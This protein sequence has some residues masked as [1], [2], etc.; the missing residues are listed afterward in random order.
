VRRLSI[1]KFI[2]YPYYAQVRA[3]KQFEA[4]PTVDTANI[5]Y[6]LAYTLDGTPV[7]YTMMPFLDRNTNTNHTLDIDTA[8][9]GTGRTLVSSIAFFSAS[10][11]GAFFKITSGAATGLVE[12]TA[13]T[14]DVSVTVRV[15]K[16]IGDATATANWEESAWSDYRGWPRS[17]CFYQQR[18]IYGGN[19][20]FPNTIWGSRIGNFQWLD[21]AGYSD[22]G[23]RT[24][25][26]QDANGIGQAVAV[27]YGTRTNIDPLR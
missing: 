9:I 23:S 1:D 14:S 2:A 24:E 18:A 4:T 7:P 27:A 22:G 17:V 26:I 16:A 5:S 3:N 19:K 13:Y 12:V 8:T 6:N 20:H 25:I 10:H 11:V 15:I 21:A